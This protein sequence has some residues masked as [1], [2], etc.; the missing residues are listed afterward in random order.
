MQK[1]EKLTF[2]W[3]SITKRSYFEWNKSTDEFIR[4][5]AKKSSNI[6]NNSELDNYDIS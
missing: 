5:I 1:K 6:Y 2:V 3:G 4:K